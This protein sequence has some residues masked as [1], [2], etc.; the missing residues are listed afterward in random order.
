MLEWLRNNLP[1]QS[2]ESSMEIW[3]RNTLRVV[4]ARVFYVLTGSLRSPFIF[5]IIQ[6]RRQRHLTWSTTYDVVSWEINVWKSFDLLLGSNL[7]PL[8]PSAGC[9]TARPPELTEVQINTFYSYQPYIDRSLV[10]SCV[11]VCVCL[12]VCVSV[13]VCRSVCICVCVCVSV[14]G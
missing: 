13:C 4:T 14:V 10:V 2:Q 5:F 7:W 6:W 1:H 3:S 11:C 8:A 12:S 9:L